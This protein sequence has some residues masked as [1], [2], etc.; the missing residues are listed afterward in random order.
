MSAINPTSRPWQVKHDLDLE[1]RT[2][3]IGNVDGELIDGTTHHSF[4][5]VCRTIDEDDDSQ[6]R[7]IAI[8]NADYIVRVVNAHDAL[9]DAIEA[10]NR[11][12][13]PCNWDDDDDPAQVAAWKKLDAALAR[14]KGGAA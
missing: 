1:G 6:S 2:T 11:D 12:A 10:I 13:R 8:A 5:F 9:V 4:D 7:S 14:A 3:L